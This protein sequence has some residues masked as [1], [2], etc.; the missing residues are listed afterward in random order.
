MSLTTVPLKTQAF[1]YLSTRILTNFWNFRFAPP[2]SKH[3]P[4]SQEGQHCRSSFLLCMISDNDVIC[5]LRPLFASRHINTETKPC[6]NQLR[7]ILPS[8]LGLQD[9][10]IQRVFSPQLPN[11]LW[12]SAASHAFPGSWAAAKE[13]FPSPP[14]YAT[15]TQV[16]TLLDQL[17]QLKLA[18]PLSLCKLFSC[19]LHA[20]WFV[21]SKS[22]VN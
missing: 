11:I 1:S 16:S 14:S 18:E 9:L 3:L 21:Q 4:L 10:L 2:S 17:L 8:K 22:V 13:A 6:R 15:H 20:S 7:E 12:K 19:R 5:R